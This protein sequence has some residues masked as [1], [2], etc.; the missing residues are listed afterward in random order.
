MIPDPSTPATV[1][2]PDE[3][4]PVVP[5]PEPPTLDRAPLSPGTR[6]APA[7]TLPTAELVGAGRYLLPVGPFPAEGTGDGQTLD[8]IS[9]EIEELP[10]AATAIL[11]HLTVRNS[12]LVLSR[13]FKGLVVEVELAEPVR[14]LVRLAIAKE[15]TAWTFGGE[16]IVW[17]RAKPPLILTLSFHSGDSSFLVA[18]LEGEVDLVDDLLR[19]LFGDRVT[20]PD[21]IAL[22]AENPALVMVGGE[23]GTKVLVAVSLRMRVDFAELP[24]VGEVIRAYG[25]VGITLGVVYASRPFGAAEI[26]AINPA[27][28]ADLQLPAPDG[29]GFSG[30]LLS[31]AIQVTGEAYSMSFPMG[32][33]EASASEPAEQTGTPPPAARK[34]D[35]NG[36]Q[37]EQDEAI[38]WFE[39]D[40]S[41]GPAHLARVGAGYWDD[42]VHF[43]VSASVLT[44]GLTFS[45]EGLGGSLPLRWP[46]EPRFNLDGLGI[47]LAVEPISI[48]GALLRRSENG[49]ERYDGM[50][51]IGAADLTIAALG[52]YDTVAG[53]PSLFVFA[54]LHRDLGG[55]PFFH[56][57]GLAAGF[58]Y[59]RGLTLPPI[60]EVKDFPLVQGAM[61]PEYFGGSTDLDK[62]FEKMREYLPAQGGNYWFAAG[63]RFTSFE[64]IE[65]AALLAVSFGAGADTVISLLGLSRMA[66]PKGAEDPVAYA[67]LQ[68]RAQFSVGSGALA[69]EG[70]LTDNS[71]IFD[72]NCRL[73]GGFAFF[74]WFSGDH[75]GDF[76]ITLG[77]YHPLFE[78]PEHYPEVPRVAIDWPVS[79]ELQV[80]GELYFALT[81]SCLMAGGKLAAVFE[82]GG[83]RAWFDA[84]A[85]FL[86][87]WQPF[88]YDVAVGISIGVSYTFRVN[89]GL[90]R[91]RTTLTVE[92]AAQIHLWGPEFAGRARVTWYVISFTVRFGDQNRQEPEWLDWDGLAGTLLPGPAAGRE[93]AATAAKDVRQAADAGDGVLTLQV[94]AGLVSQPLVDGRPWPIVN[95]HQLEIMT[96]SAVPSTVLEVNGEQQTLDGIP[97]LGIRPMDRRTLESTYEVTLEGSGGE[98]IGVEPEVE[99]Q[100]VPAAIWSPEPPEAT[101]SAEV[102]KDVPTG[103]RFTIPTPPPS[104]ALPPVDLELLAVEPIPKRIDWREDLKPPEPAPA[105]PTWAGTLADAAVEQRRATVLAA[106]QSVTPQILNTPD[107]T[108]LAA[109]ADRVYQASPQVA[110]LGQSFEEQANV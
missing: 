96:A 23:D 4:A 28:S 68:L 78:P 61:D 76:V 31:A 54:V 26:K 34:S 41:I 67:E 13:Q 14:A 70:R 6:P 71:Y 90:A 55:P 93:N 86:L 17:R 62:A 37:D 69:I 8:A 82:T 56:V 88:F 44:S 45:V 7:T 97:P 110:H 109:T 87:S 35:G 105:G 58:G 77:G 100:G 9:S 95:S 102:I 16:V 94:T 84:Y 91:V 2:L 64:M 33:S 80:R 29:D 15:G 39:V 72:R 63:V 98:P 38:Q 57:T 59:N 103:V 47:G 51:L 27:L 85:D 81:P 20:V 53:E 50:A 49:V 40:R 5:L 65:S 19:P 108:V 52:S 75:A 104:H 21:G 73:T 32:G 60:D 74:T 89:L 24:F 18:A 99:R 11:G 1:S 22:R 42:A 12:F 3:E 92:L 106:L 101:P 79:D 25:P 10:P 48:T 107:L 30:L 66:V 43:R 46:P 83:L 36:R